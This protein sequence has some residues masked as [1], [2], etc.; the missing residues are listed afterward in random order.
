MPIPASIKNWIVYHDYKWLFVI[1]YVTLAV[2]LSIAISL[3][4]LVV[5]VAVHA[6]LE[7]IRQYYQQPN[8]RLVLLQ[9]LWE[10]KLDIA[11]VL[12]ALALSLYMDAVLGILGIRS[13]A[14]LG[15]GI[16]QGAVRGG[17]RI[18]AWQ[19]VLRGVLLSLD[20]LV[21]VLRAIRRSILGRGAQTDM[22]EGVSEP[23][24]AMEEEEQSNPETPQKGHDQAADF[25]SQWGD[26]GGRWG[27]G[28]WLSVGLGVAC[29][30]LMLLAPMTTMSFNEMV[31]MLVVE[32]HPYP[33][34]LSA[35]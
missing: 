7:I 5:V 10:V 29:I 6:V 28:D 18:A 16:T 22:T 25:S 30:A 3:F 34:L 2:V 33:Q 20:D 8:M 31:N 23:V 27:I 35:D 26:W 11:L 21:H 14:Q 15:S 13:V 24:N 4:W 32:L 19:R 1:S 9:A 12:F 17:A